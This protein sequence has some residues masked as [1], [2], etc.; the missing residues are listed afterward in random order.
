MLD[1]TP[2]APDHITYKNLWPAVLTKHAVRVTEVNAICARLKKKNEL[3]F[4]DW[5]AREAQPEDHYRMQ[6]PDGVT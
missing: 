3:V 5:E 4:L 6:R 1:L 2:K